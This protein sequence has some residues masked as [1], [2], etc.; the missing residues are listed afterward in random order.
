MNNQIKFDT[1]TSLIKRVNEFPIVEYEGVINSGSLKVGNY[2]FYFK[3]C[4]YDGNET[5]I[6]AESGLVSIFKG[7]DGDPFS[8]DGGINDI[9]CVPIKRAGA[10]VLVAGSAVFGA[11]DRAHMIESI[12]NN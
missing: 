12:R 3:Y 7:N 5:D 11:D 10:T 8:I 2:T 9:T 6:I 4:D 1:D